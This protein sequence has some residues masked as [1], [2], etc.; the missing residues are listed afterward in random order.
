MTE[1][2]PV[3]F[4]KWA[5]CLIGCAVASVMLGAGCIAVTLLAIRMQEKAN[6]EFDSA[7]ARG[8]EL[9]RQGSY[10]LAR[11]QFGEALRVQGSNRSKEQARRAQLACEV[12]LGDGR[13]MGDALRSLTGAQLQELHFSEHCPEF[14]KLPHPDA[15]DQLYSYLREEVRAEALKR[16]AP[17]SS[18]RIWFSEV[19]REEF[20]SERACSIN[21]RIKRR[22]EQSLLRELARRVVEEQP[23]QYDRVLLHFLV[24]AESMQP[25]ATVSFAPD[26][27]VEILGLSVEEE[28]AAKKRIRDEKR[29]AQIAA[30]LVVGQ[31]QDE[32]GVIEIYEYEDSLYLEWK[33]YDGSESRLQLETAYFP[34]APRKT[35]EHL[36]V[37]ADGLIRVHDK[38]G[39]ELR[40]LPRAAIEQVP[41]RQQLEGAWSTMNESI[42]IK[43]RDGV[44]H[45][46]RT[47]GRERSSWEVEPRFRN[48][49]RPPNFGEYY[50]LSKRGNLRIYDRDGFIRTARHVA[51]HHEPDA[52]KSAGAL[53][54]APGRIPSD[55][56][57][58]LGGTLHKSTLG[59]WKRASYRNRLATAA[60][61]VVT[62]MKPEKPSSLTE[63]K[64]FAKELEA[65][66]TATAGGDSQLDSSSTAGVAAAAW[67]LV[68]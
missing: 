14:A 66:I 27:S 36:V 16:R 33:F 54:A 5:A 52:S 26:I 12:M 4:N 32:F 62:L 11:A 45:A 20:R 58:Y 57:W 42:V 61:F 56:K 21:V 60:D 8:H 25:W 30:R 34:V 24:D 55:S 18:F 22:V 53:P 37:G 35:S 65:S 67:L 19:S 40:T 44:F 17:R 43:E 39:R 51:S 9:L 38:K 68:R 59:Q 49:E 48:S 1:R 23:F 46:T 2:K 13:A 6:E 31:W 50:V 63:L 15:Q 28:Y 47:A 7:V 29:A 10:Q 3:R 64:K 41:R